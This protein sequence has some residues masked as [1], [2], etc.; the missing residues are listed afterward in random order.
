MLKSIMKSFK[1]VSD[2]RGCNNS[3]LNVQA[4]QSWQNTRF[5]KQKSSVCESK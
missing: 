5:S 2:S 1:G 3:L 4:S